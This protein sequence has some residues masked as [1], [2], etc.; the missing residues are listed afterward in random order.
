M[1]VDQLTTALGD[2]YRIQRELGQGG[3]AVVY[4]ADDL[5]HER[6]VA[7][8][9]LRPEVAR[10]LGAARFLNEIRTTAGLAHPHILPLHDSGEAGELLYYVMPFVAGESLRQRLDREGALPL[11]DALRITREVAD[12]LG[13]AHQRQII[14][15]DIKPENILLADGHAFVAD[16]G[17]ARALRLTGD[18]RITRT[19]TSI[20]TPAYMSPEQA[21][22]ES[23][24]DARSDLYSLA[25]VV[26]EMVIGQ[27]P[28][29]GQTAEAVLVKRFTSSPP[30]LP[31][32]R[33]DLPVELG[34]ALQRA[35]AREPDDR[36]PS[37]AEFLAALDPVAPAASGSSIRTAPRPSVARHTVGRDAERGELRSAFDSARQG[38]GLLFCVT[39][40]PGIGKT[41]FVEDVLAQL[42]AEESVTIA[43]G[44]CSERLAGTDAYL[45]HLEALEG[46]LRTEG[47]ECAQAMRDLAPTWY[48]QVA[49]Q[50]DSGERAALQREMESASQ[51]RMKRELG[52][53]VAA[54]A[55]LRPLVLFI[56]DLHWADVSTVDL[57]SYLAGRFPDTRMLVVVTYR[58]SD[59]LLTRHPFLQVK[60]DL[61]SRGLC[62]ELEL[63][64]LTLADIVA[65]LAM[66]F[67]GHR[68]PKDLA[69]LILAKTEGSPL[70]MADLVRYLRDSGV[71]RSE[72]DGWVLAQAMPDLERVL[73]ESVRGMIERKI[74][75][76]SDE[77]RGLL[78][79]ASV[80]GYE[81]DSAVVAK[82][83]NREPLDIETRLEDVE[84]VHALVRVVEER[85]LP[86]RSPSLKYRFVHALYQNALYATLRATRRTQIHTAVA[87][88]L[89]TLW[90]EKTA[91]VAQELALLW[92]GAREPARAAG[93]LLTAAR[94]AFEVHANHES[95]ALAAR[96]IALLEGLPESRD[97]DRRELALQ[98]A[99]GGALRI[100]RGYGEA[101][102]GKAYRRAVL[103]AERA[104]DDS[105]LVAILRGLWEFHE[106]RAEYDIALNFAKELFTFADRRKDPALLIVAHDALGDTSLWT[107]DLRAARRHLER[108]VELYDRQG[109]GSDATLFGYDSGAACL[110][111]LALS[112]WYLGCPDQ[113]LRRSEE[114]MELATKLGT[115]AGMAQTMFFTAWVHQLRGEI[116]T[117]STRTDQL[118]ALCE[119]QGIPMYLAAG[120]LLKGV[121]LA[122]Q[123]KAD[124]GV[125]L[126][127]EGIAGHRATG[128]Q[129]GA[130]VWS[131]AWLAEGLLRAG[132]VDDAVQVITEALA[133]VERTGERFHEAELWRLR[134]EAMPRQGGSAAETVAALER[135]LASARQGNAKSL[136]LRAAIALARVREGRAELARVHEWFGEGQETRDLRAAGALLT[137]GT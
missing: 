114:A 98:V 77:D 46:L 106:L 30:R 45:P 5:K 123:G 101:E 59:L 9:V 115:P 130:S 48:A 11:P 67:P 53:F 81:F 65:Y 12:A 102:V 33:S 24:V 99:A 13:Y 41:T 108:G 17:I 32:S 70:F 96:G 94:Q 100:T 124:E 14:H 79:A 73:P 15:R 118:I 91:D 56:D 43:R 117:A 27:A 72:P 69:A 137:A 58:P 35:L 66:V 127:R 39:G 83:L 64:F 36:F 82:A 122:E 31:D 75:Q 87:G 47:A 126:M 6:S 109:L 1:T 76:L 22:G 61:Q 55:R 23:S 134:A 78:V 136:E 10:A 26:Y 4:L 20:G 57:L 18:A 132:R 60:P 16:F 103:L 62:R 54:M 80:Q 52:A 119:E 51:E 86:D 68:F 116:A 113:A 107:G 84:R 50:P 93:Y 131:G 2:R 120:R 49:V 135:A 19:G 8:K 44:R 95:A 125:A 128:T 63:A 121:L 88:A 28:W 34:D 110:S 111:F 85:E 71:I 133:F 92:E 42:G 38:R 74:G 89:E 21:F 29:T 112:L 105:Q 104:R 129:L 3:M 25:C 90:G 7:I 40:E 97:R 37:A